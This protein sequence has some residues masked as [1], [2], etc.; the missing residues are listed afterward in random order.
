LPGSSHTIAVLPSVRWPS[1]SQDYFIIYCRHSPTQYNDICW[2][3]SPFKPLSGQKQTY[4]IVN[5]FLSDDGKIS[6]VEY[7]KNEITQ[8][9]HRKPN[10]E[11]MDIGL[12]RMEEIIKE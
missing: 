4:F 8:L 9:L 7:L 11:E 1:N 10:K 12:E 5:L 2:C 3:T 6:K